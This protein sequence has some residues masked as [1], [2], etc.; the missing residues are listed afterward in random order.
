MVVAGSAEATHGS[1]QAAVAR[2]SARGR[3]DQRFGVVVERLGTLRGVTL[4]ASQARHVA[5]DDRG[6]IVLAGEV[7]DDDY[8]LRDDLGK[9]YPAIARLHG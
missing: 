5:L 4:V 3:L 9:T 8:E 2:L 7:Y 6:R 1:F